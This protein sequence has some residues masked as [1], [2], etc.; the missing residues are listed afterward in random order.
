MAAPSNF[1]SKVQ[2]FLYSLPEHFS[3]DMSKSRPAVLVDACLESKMSAIA[4]RRP[5][6]P[7]VINS[8]K[9]FGTSTS[10]I[11]S[12]KVVFFIEN[13]TSLQFQKI[14]K[15]IKKQKLPQLGS[16]SCLSQKTIIK[17]TLILK[18]GCLPFNKQRKTH[19]LYILILRLIINLFLIV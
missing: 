9:L 15:I 19:F 1:F 8:S 5:V 7:E 2:I 17:R 13:A 11:V 3:A 12:G 4:F 18:K 6:L 16:A 14:A 10:A